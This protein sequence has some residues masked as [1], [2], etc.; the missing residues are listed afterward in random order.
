MLVYPPSKRRDTLSNIKETQYFTLNHITEKI[1]FRAHQTAAAYSTDKSEFDM[2][3]LTPYFSKYL[4]A[5][6]VMESPI[7]IGLKVREEI[8]ITANNKI[9]IIGE[10]IEVFTIEN[11]VLKDGMIDIGMAGTITS[12][13]M[14]T[15]YA[16]RKIARLTMAK[17]NDDLSIKG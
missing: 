11:C 7:K 4:P 16:T 10:V 14:D 9:L 2:V 1:Y 8:P 17:T 15:Y 13:G 3:K 12:A 5:P 6:Y